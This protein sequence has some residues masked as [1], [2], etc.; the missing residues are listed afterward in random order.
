MQ[1]LHFWWRHLRI[2]LAVFLVLAGVLASTSLDVAIAQASYFDSSSMQWIGAGNWWIDTVIHTWGRWFIRTVAALAMA[3]W[4][5][6]CIDLNLR[7]LQRPVGYLLVSLVV[8]IGIVGI[9]KTVTN[10]DCPWDLSAFG[11]RFPYLGLFEDRPDALRQARCFPAAHA[12]SGYAL[13]ALYFALRE[14]SQVLARAGLASGITIGLIFG[15]AQ[16]S[17][18]AHFISHDLW[19]AFLVWATSLSIYSFAFKS[20]L[21]NPVRQHQ[22]GLATH[23]KL[24]AAAGG[25]VDGIDADVHNGPCGLARPARR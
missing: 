16:Q 6:T 22:A 25:R 23:E 5:A 15:I 20:R 2:P 21:W 19:S 3:L 17:R 18:G 24:L 12:S 11:G 10:V 1:H 9:L 4:I 8:S 7:H 14:R 13:L